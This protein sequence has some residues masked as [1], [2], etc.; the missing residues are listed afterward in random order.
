MKESK[1]NRFAVNLNNK[2]KKNILR[3][4]QHAIKN[5]N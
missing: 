1:L 3:S 4:T 5:R 2:K